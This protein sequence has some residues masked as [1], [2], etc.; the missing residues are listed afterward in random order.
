MP[1]SNFIIKRLLRSIRNLDEYSEEDIDVA[2]YGFEALLWEIEKNV[3]FF[4]IFFILGYPSEWLFSLFVIASVRFFAGGAHV[5]SVW[6]CFFLTLLSL[7]APIF[8]FPLIIPTNP[9][10]IA[11]VGL[12]SLLMLVLMAPLIP[13]NRRK[14]VDASKHPVKKRTAIC[15]TV[16]WL[17]IIFYYQSHPLATIALWTIFLQN[18]QLF[19]ALLNEKGIKKRGKELKI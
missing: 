2:R 18:V 3:Y 4:V 19:A 10:S 1:I 16:M 8:A 12:F 17:G 15:I 9:I 6:G 5:K 14:L 7:L 11:L 13:E